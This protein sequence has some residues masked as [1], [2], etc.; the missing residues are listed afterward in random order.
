MIKKKRANSR[1]VS[2]HDVRAI[3]LSMPEVEETTAYG[4]SAF[5][6]GKKRFAGQP[7]ER[8]DIEPNTLGVGLS[9]EER[10]ARIAARPDVYYLTQ[11]FTAYPAVLVRL[12]K[13]RRDELRELLAAAWHYAM[14][15]A[16]AGR[17]KRSK[18]IAR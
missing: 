4:M 14:D 6:A 17:K 3:A 18:R 9:F 8:P 10:D 2:L 12:D 1:P 16:A 11:H 13:I 7:V 5:K 15:G